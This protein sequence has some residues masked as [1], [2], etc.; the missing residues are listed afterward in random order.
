MATASTRHSTRLAAVSIALW[1]I[2]A[3]SWAQTFTADSAMPVKIEIIQACT[4]SATD[5]DFGQYNLSSP[6]PALGQTQIRVTCGAGVVVELSLDNGLAPGPNT[7][8]RRMRQD[9][10]NDR[11]NYGLFQDAGRTMHWGD[12]PGVDT[13]EMVTT[14]YPQ[15]VPIYGEIPAG[16]RANDG[17]YSDEITVR[18]QF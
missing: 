3:T 2:S 12:K 7:S 15:T 9:A 18:L 6:S 10:G 5:L 8:R 11:L 14:G 13:R 16:Q 4:I 1:G 17:T